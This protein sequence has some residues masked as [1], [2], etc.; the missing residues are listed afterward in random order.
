[1]SACGESSI[2]RS[3]EPP[4]AVASALPPVS[5]HVGYNGSKRRRRF[6]MRLIAGSSG[7]SPGERLPRWILAHVGEHYA[8]GRRVP[9]HMTA[10]QIKSLRGSHWYMRGHARVNHGHARAR[11]GHARA[12]HGHARAHYVLTPGEG[13]GP[14]AH[15]TESRSESE[16]GGLHTQGVRTPLVGNHAPS[17]WLRDR[18]SG[19]RTRPW[20]PDVASGTSPRVIIYNGG[21]LVN[22][23]VRLS[24]CALPGSE[25]ASRDTRVCFYL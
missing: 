20:Y 14:Q 22:S 21:G 13:K 2:T 16:P 7:K 3:H 1:M 6:L 11:Y 24:S 10:T 18:G 17:G 25:S 9:N 23:H 5:A 19:L 12:H 15:T 8:C 4:I